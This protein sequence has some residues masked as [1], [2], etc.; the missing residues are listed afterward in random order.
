MHVE[1]D[2]GD[3]LVSVTVVFEDAHG[4]YQIKEGDSTK[5]VSPPPN[6]IP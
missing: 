4:E 2:E 1:E 5:Y 6:H 3:A